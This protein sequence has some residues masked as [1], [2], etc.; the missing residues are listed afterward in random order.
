M[1]LTM[2]FPVNKCFLFGHCMWLT[3]AT[4]TTGQLKLT[5][6]PVGTA[7]LRLMM[8]MVESGCLEMEKHRVRRWM[9]SRWLRER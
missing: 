4:T 3:R 5:M 2:R 9:M 7:G 1:M 6:A 8:R